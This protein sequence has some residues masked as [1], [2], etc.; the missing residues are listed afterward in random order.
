MNQTRGW[1]LIYVLLFFIFTVGTVSLILIHRQLPSPIN[2]PTST[3]SNRDL[4]IETR[5]Y[6]SQPLI[7]PTSSSPA[8]SAL[9]PPIPTADTPPASKPLRKG[10]ITTKETGRC[11]DISYIA[12]RLW[13]TSWREGDLQLWVQERNGYSRVGERN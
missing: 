7:Q 2:P 1:V 3:R 4:T 12:K 9:N 11:S 10:S 5:I 8:T 13:E 6:Q